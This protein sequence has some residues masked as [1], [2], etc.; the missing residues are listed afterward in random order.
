MQATAT[1]TRRQHPMFPK[2]QAGPWERVLLQRKGARVSGIT[3]GAKNSPTSKVNRKSP[4]KLNAGSVKGQAVVIPFPRIVR[5][6]RLRVPTWFDDPEV[7]LSRLQ[8]IRGPQ[9]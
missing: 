7:V 1:S 4:L 2:G 3:R 6:D 5:N 8:N 9:W